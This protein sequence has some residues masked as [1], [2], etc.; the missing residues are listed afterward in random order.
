MKIILV[1]A[2]ISAM[3]FRINPS[4]LNK[5]IT[6]QPGVNTDKCFTWNVAYLNNN[7]PSES[8]RF[9]IQVDGLNIHIN[10]ELHE[11]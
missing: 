1:P 11:S 6:I 5:K 10:E 7:P 4:Y 9:S 8:F 2:V 3:C